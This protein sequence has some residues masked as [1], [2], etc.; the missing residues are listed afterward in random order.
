MHGLQMWC[1]MGC[2]YHPEEQEF[3]IYLIVNV[4]LNLISLILDAGIHC[5]K[6][7]FSIRS[8]TWEIGKL[9]L[10]KRK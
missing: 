6:D 10:V 4:Y 5:P 8:S 7:S 9:I 1:V 2:D 3:I